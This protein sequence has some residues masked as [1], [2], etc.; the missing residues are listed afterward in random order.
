MVQAFDPGK[1]DELVHYI[2]NKCDTDKLG[3]IKLNK[4]LWF[5]DII[6]FMVKGESITG[7]AY[8]KREFGPVPRPMSGSL[9]R[10][11]EEGKLSVTD[12][13]CFGLPKKE[14]KSLSAPP[15]DTLA[16]EEVSLVDEV[17]DIIIGN[18]TAH[19]ISEL[20]HDEI[21]E[22]AEIGEEIPYE[23]VLVSNLGEID[24]LDM[25]WAYGVLNE[26]LAA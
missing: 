7:A 5:S 22:M 13:V 2:C 14:F 12:T 3:K 18:H 24:E 15:L 25:E 19:S 10:L 1:F 23:A 6:H 20:T 11:E 26:R 17:M 8:I 21:W 9:K 16:A 4:I